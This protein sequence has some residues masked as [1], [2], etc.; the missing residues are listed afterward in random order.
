MVPA[1]GWRQ[2][3]WLQFP[4]ALTRA[5]PLFITFALARAPTSCSGTARFWVLQYMNSAVEQR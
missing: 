4:L 3:L 2:R 5:S 1:G